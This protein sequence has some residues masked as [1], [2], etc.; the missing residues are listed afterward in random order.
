MSCVW[1]EEIDSILS[2]GKYLE[3]VGVRNWALARDVALKALNKFLERDVAVSGGDVYLSDGTEIELSY[4]N[5]SCEPR[6]EES[7]S[8]FLHRS[9]E[10][11]REFIERYKASSGSALFAIV[12][13]V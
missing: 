4:D 5:W 10:E 13:K 12:P 9:I 8:D 6:N 7:E 3:D 11:A 2:D 1:T